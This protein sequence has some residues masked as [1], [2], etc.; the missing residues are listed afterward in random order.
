M[1]EARVIRSVIPFV[2]VIS[3]FLP[4]SAFSEEPLVNAVNASDDQLE[5]ELQYLQEETYVITP[6]KIPNESRKRPGPSMW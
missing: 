2:M 6:S 5:D 1:S 4:L 3:L